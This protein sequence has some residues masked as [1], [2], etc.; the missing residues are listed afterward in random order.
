MASPPAPYIPANYLGPSS[1]VQF[2]HPP[3]AAGLTLPP[4]CQHGSF[5]SPSMCG[6]TVGYNILLPPSYER[7]P[8]ARFPIC[9]YLHGRG[10]D[11][12]Y[13]LLPSE[14]GVLASLFSAME[15]GDSPEV[16]YVMAHAGRHGGYC[17]S[18]SLTPKLSRVMGETVII[19]ELLPHIH[20]TYRTLKDM[21]CAIQGWSMGGQ[22]ALLL[23]F[24]HPAL[25][26]SVVAMAPGLCTGAELKEELPQ[27]FAV[28]HGSNNGSSG[29][30]CSSSGS[31][32]GGGGGNGSAKEDSEDA[33]V[34]EYDRTSAWGWV[35][36][37]AEAI[38]DGGSGSG[39]GGGQGRGS[40]LGL[41]IR[42]IC[43]G[44]DSQLYRSRRMHDVLSHLGIPHEYEEVPGVGHDSGRIYPAQSLAAMQF[45]GRHFTHHT[46]TS[47]GYD[48][49]YAGRAHGQIK[50]SG[51]STVSGGS[52]DEPDLYRAKM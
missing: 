27:V 8:S 20:K 47:T 12:N 46:A 50:P 10:D 49:V 14:G 38:R 28:M 3:D 34:K 29:S 6:V 18:H 1:G 4:F 52:V 21:P 33:D 32:S 5:P 43:G 22:G 40:G 44:D 23:A 17:D 31:G 9:F 2:N 41:G 37:N 30:V 11:E 39:S 35:E 26:S 25:F 51:V 13:Q 19:D 7:V 24:K 48:A 42:I 16:I 36:R 45:H 15:Q